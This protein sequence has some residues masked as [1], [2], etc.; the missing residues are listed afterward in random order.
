MPYSFQLHTATSGQTTFSFAS[1]DGFVTADDLSVY[2]N[3]VLQ[4][5]SGVYTVNT[6][7]FNVVFLSGRTAGD[8]VLVR[9]FTDALRADREVD[10]VDG[11]ILTAA[12][13]DNS[14]LQLLYLVQ[15]GLDEAKEFCLRLNDALTAWDAKNKKIT[16][17]ATPTLGTDAVNKD[18]VDNV[19]FGGISGAA[20]TVFATPN[21]ASGSASLRTL[22]GNDVPVLNSI[23]APTGSLSMSSQKIINLLDPTLAQDATTKN[24]C[25]TTFLNPNPAIYTST[26]SGPAGA[27]TYSTTSGV[28]TNPTSGAVRIQL[29]VNLLPI[30]R[31]SFVDGIIGPVD[32]S[33]AGPHW[34]ALSNSTGSN[35][36]VR[37][38]FAKFD[39]LSARLPTFGL[40]VQAP[41]GWDIPEESLPSGYDP[42][43]SGG[44]GVFGAWSASGSWGTGLITVNA[45]SLYK[46]W[47][48]DD[49]TQWTGSHGTGEAIVGI[50]ASVD[51]A[52]G[53]PPNA[54]STYGYRNGCYARITA[55]LIR[56]N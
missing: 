44:P 51:Q 2:V 43:A 53:S 32:G 40:A 17:V 3:G 11:S 19:A 13:L 48:N 25:D 26:Y 46:F 49:P 39:W 55:V 23:R 27:Q 20:N 47:R 52:N 33:N 34:F 29:N 28:V 24:Y 31:V 18:Y 56:M 8:T 12:D 21:G 54:T 36:V 42:S 16:N 45:N 10:F 4:A 7:T 30:R 9:R 37:M 5:T 41:Q 1:I 15:E 50:G 14:A 6:T 35:I 22:V 38:L